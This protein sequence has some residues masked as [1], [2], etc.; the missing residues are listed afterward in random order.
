MNNAQ[1]L[2]ELANQL[3]ESLLG[4]VLDFAEFL[5]QKQAPAQTTQTSSFASHFGALKQTPL[6]NGADP[7]QVQQVLRDE[8]N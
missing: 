8:W 2:L 3:P 5:Q 4:E 6:F 1:R 7:I